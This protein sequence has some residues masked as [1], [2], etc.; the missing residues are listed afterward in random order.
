LKVGGCYDPGTTIY[1]RN[2]SWTSRRVD[3]LS[4]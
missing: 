4:L 1:I 2:T 3:G